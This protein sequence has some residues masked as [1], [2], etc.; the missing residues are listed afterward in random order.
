[1]SKKIRQEFADQMLKLGSK[2]RSIVV[3]VGDISHGILQPFA[4]KNHDRYYNIGICEQSI[5]NMAAG[6]SKVG[7]NPI[8]HTIAPF[9]TER[10]Y[11]QIKLDFGYQKQNVN[12]ITVGGSFDY[13]K[14]G[15]SH[16]CYTDVSIISHLKNSNIIIPGSTKEFEVLFKSIYKKK[17]INYFRIPEYTHG[18]SFTENQIK[19]G[20]SITI[21][22]GKDITIATTGTLLKN[23]LKA[24]KLL[25]KIGYSAEIKYFH[26][27]KPFDSNSIRKSVKKTKCLLTV[28]E[29][30]SHDGIYNQCLKSIIDLNNIS[31]GQLA[32]EDFIHNYGTYEELCERVG[33]GVKNIFNKV[34]K[35]ILKKN[36]TKG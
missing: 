21:Q 9:I 1:M 5:V 31:T 25:N 7:L 22:K 26:T 36:A 24:S 10:A 6:L 33:L 17:N 16:H 8:V 15:C 29:L 20:K 28:E 32:I 14:L 4:K 12:L 30:S 23:V 35:I 18:L 2:D 13:S 27:I 19:F 3:L 11:E 34:K